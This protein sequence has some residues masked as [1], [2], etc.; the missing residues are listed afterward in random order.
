MI[1]FVVS[2][3]LDARVGGAANANK[4]AQSVGKLK[5]R[6]DEAYK[7]LNIDPSAYTKINPLTAKTI[8]EIYTKHSANNDPAKGGSF[9]LQ[10][11]I[12][13]AK[14]ALE[15][16]IGHTAKA[17]DTVGAEA[18]GTDGEEKVDGASQE[19][20]VKKGEQT[21]DAQQSEKKNEKTS[22]S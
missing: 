11:K 10:S 18:A 5:M 4:M 21:S 12:F 1:D 14:E 22:S 19:A 3:C 16:E 15:R 6:S 13:R 17:D 2:V 8:E 20:D 9:Y 7:I